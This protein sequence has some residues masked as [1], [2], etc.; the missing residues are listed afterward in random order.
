MAEQQV[1][2]R[3][4]GRAFTATGAFIAGTCLAISG[5]LMD[6]AEEGELPLAKGQVGNLHWFLAL[7]FIAFAVNHIRL[8]WRPL[9]AHVRKRVSE[10]KPRVEWLLALLLVIVVGAT[11]IATAPSGPPPGARG[12]ERGE[13]PHDD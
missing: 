6:A 3:F 1:V 12:G 13:R 4:N 10:A 2:R 11:A 9:T 8:N 7:L 5:L